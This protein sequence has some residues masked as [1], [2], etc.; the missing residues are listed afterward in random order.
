MGAKARNKTRQAPAT[1]GQVL[2]AGNQ[3]SAT[4]GQV[5]AVGS[6]APAVG[7]Q[8]PVEGN[9]ALSMEVQELSFAYG[10]HQVLSDVSFVV[11]KGQVTSILGSNGSGKSTLFYLMTKNL[12]QQ[13]GRILLGGRDIRSIRVREYA[14][15]VSIVNQSNS[16]N[17][18]LSVKRLVSYG[19]TPFHS[20][21]QGLGPEDER[22]IEWA[23]DITDVQKYHNK[24]LSQL[25]G[26]QRQRVWLAMALA[27]N[28]RLLL[29]DEPTTFLD[30][31]YQVEILRLIR[32]LNQEFGITIIMVLHDMNQAIYYSDH[33][34]CLRD[35][36]VLAEG[37]PNEIMSSQLIDELYGIHLP[38]FNNE[39]GQFVLQ[40]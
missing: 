13:K 29:L 26:G 37:S 16:V 11:P 14:R 2:V 36:C 24:P 27:Q 30:I 40:I 18:D 3:A 15:H 35:G 33:L 20:F 5:P 31:R 10:A 22:L 12:H 38:M 32:R 23:M 21:M 39:Q 28:T 4:G 8:A 19:R 17:G 1:G 7:G 25:S 6:Q 9:Q 34:L